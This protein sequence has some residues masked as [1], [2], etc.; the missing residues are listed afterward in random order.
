M[1]KI[2]LLRKRL[3][4]QSQHRGMKEMDLILGGF[5]QQFL[6]HMSYEEL[7]QFQD[8]LAFPDQNLYGWLFEKAPL[9]ENVPQKLIG[10]IDNFIKSK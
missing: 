1:E 4:Y 9:P 3:Y 10:M 5:A 8:L 6:D 7:L 2:D